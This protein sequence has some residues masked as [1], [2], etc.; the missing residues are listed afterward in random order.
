MEKVLWA[1]GVVL[2]LVGYVTTFRLMYRCEINNIYKDVAECRS[3]DR[4]LKNYEAGRDPELRM[5]SDHTFRTGDW[6][7]LFAPLT[8][9]M[10]SLMWPVGLIIFPLYFIV[11]MLR[12][13]ARHTLLNVE[14][15]A[16]ASWEYAVREARVT[17]W[18]TE[19][20]RLQK[21]LAPDTPSTLHESI[22]MLEQGIPVPQQW[23]HGV[24]N[25]DTA[26]YHQCVEECKC[27]VSWQK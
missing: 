9:G 2:Y 16:K 10:I 5:C 7:K 18:T 22:K 6:L 25:N 21:E 15:E 24:K 19:L 14:S 20:S 8:F 11:L 1:T 12:W 27:S 26:Y 3:C 23:L 4:D 17:R 13:L